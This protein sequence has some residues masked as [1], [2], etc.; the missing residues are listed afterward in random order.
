MSGTYLGK[1]HKLAWIKQSQRIE[2]L[3]DRA[4]RVELRRRRQT[5]E[6]IDLHLPDAMLGRD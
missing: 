4:N 3:F 1:G 2:R 6:F 5:G